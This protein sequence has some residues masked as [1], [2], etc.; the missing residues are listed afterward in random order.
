MGRMYIAPIDI[1]TA[2]TQRDILEIAVGDNR[3]IVVHEILIT[4]DVEGDANEEAI[5]L[6]IAR[7]TGS[8]TSGTT[9]LSTPVAVNLDERGVAD[10]ATI[11]TGATTQ[12]VVGTGAKA[13]LAN[14]FVNNRAG[15]HYLPPPESRINIS[16]DGTDNSGLVVAMQAAAAATLAWGGYVVFEELG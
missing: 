13:T 15:L 7:Y 8:Y 1:A 14:I 4:T 12:A 16:H 10:G 3:S 6:E 5:E 11:T 2:V 9:G